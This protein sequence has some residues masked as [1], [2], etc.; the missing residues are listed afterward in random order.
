MDREY[1]E[2]VVR[3]FFQKRIRDR[4]LWELGNEKKRDDALWRLT[5]RYNEHLI[6][7]YM[8]EVSNHKH[9]TKH[10]DDK[11]IFSLL[12]SHGAKD[13]CYA[14]SFNKKIDGQFLTLKEALKEAVDYSWPSIISCIPGKLAYFEGE[15]GFGFPPR[16]ILKRDY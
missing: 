6:Q 2:I 12:K 14:I 3:S 9:C 13:D 11:E 5:H 15:S 16:F 4:V 10:P 8:I 7:K 1:E